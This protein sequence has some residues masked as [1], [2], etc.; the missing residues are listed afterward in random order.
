MYQSLGGPRRSQNASGKSEAR[1][2]G[3]GTQAKTSGKGSARW[4]NHSVQDTEV[5]PTQFVQEAT[6]VVILP[7]QEE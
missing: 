3:G 7:G 4:R 6:W 5:G 2:V 1:G